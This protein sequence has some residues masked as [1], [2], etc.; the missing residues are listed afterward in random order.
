M[1]WSLPRLRIDQVMMTCLKYFLPI[2]CALLVGVCLWLLLIPP[3]AARVVQYVLAVGCAVALLAVF[4]S[5][6]RTPPQGATS[7]AALPGA[8]EGLAVRAKK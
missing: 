5:L 3:G 8:W 4:V 7:R 6:F 2:S 1:R